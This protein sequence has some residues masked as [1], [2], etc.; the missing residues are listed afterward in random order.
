MIALRDD[1]GDD[2]NAKRLLPAVI[3]SFQRLSNR[4]PFRLLRDN[5]ITANIFTETGLWAG[6]RTGYNVDLRR[7]DRVASRIVTGLFFHETGTRLP[8]THV[9]T[10]YSESGLVDLSEPDRRRI[11]DICAKLTSRAPITI[12]DIF[13]YWFQLNSEDP[14]TSAW[15]LCF[16]GK[17]AFV[18]MTLPKNA[19]PS[20][21][22][23]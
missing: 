23:A 7:L 19:R 5:M 20:D 15:L 9:A 17:V 2:P 1:V 6:R 4:G 14:A 13:A 18:G 12:G 22:G 8:E 11:Q 21:V 16:F 10:S 3:R